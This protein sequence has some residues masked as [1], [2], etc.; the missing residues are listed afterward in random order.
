MKYESNDSDPFD[1][2]CGDIWLPGVPDPVRKIIPGTYIR[3][4]RFMVLVKNEKL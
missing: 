1:F 3:F 4:P 2:G